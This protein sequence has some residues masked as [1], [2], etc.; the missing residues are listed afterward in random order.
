MRA[1]FDVRRFAA[2]ALLL[3]VAGPRGF[4][5]DE[6][7]IA[8]FAAH[9]TAEWRS[10]TVGSSDIELRAGPSPGQF[11]YTWTM[12][13][14]GIFRLVYNSDVVQKSWISLQGGHV[15]PDRYRA[16]QG[17]SSLEIAFDWNRGRARGLEQ[18]KPV[19][20]KLPEGTQDILSIQIETMLDLRNGNLPKSFPILD[21]DEIKEFDYAVEGPARIRTALGMLDTVVVASQRA[22]NNRLL[23]M[24]FAP[25]LGYVPVQ[26]ER[27]RDGKLEFAMR[28]KAVSR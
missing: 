14:R 17:D 25:S 7:S 23:H 6:E 26:A 12:T 15:R 2:A 18:G 10:I 20:L 21:K 19:D 9:Y 3:A 1:T 13:A 28:I 5:A 22:G 8:P 11:L 27:S 24:W 4:A 16:E